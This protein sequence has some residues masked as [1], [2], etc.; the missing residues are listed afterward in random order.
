MPRLVVL[1]LFAVAIAA[2]GGSR[3]PIL[4]AEPALDYLIVQL[5]SGGARA[6]SVDGIAPSLED[7]GFRRIPVPPGYT[8]DEYAAELRSLPGFISVVPDV[9]AYAAALPDDPLFPVNQAAY[10]GLIKAP[11]AWD[12]ST[13]AAHEVIVAVLDSGMDTRHPELNS[14]LWENIRDASRDGIDDDNNGC[15]DDLNG[16]RF[17]DLTSSNRDGCGYSSSAATGN[18]LDDHGRAGSDQNSHGTLVAG[19]IG[20]AGNN[21][22]GLTG[23]SWDVRLMPVKVLDCGPTGSPSGSVY[24]VAQGIDYARRMGAR[25]I[26]LSLAANGATADTPVLRKAVADAEAQGVIIVAAAGNHTPSSSDVGPG[27][28]AAYTQ[29]SN[30][31]AVGASDLNGDWATFSNYGPALD[32]AAP[33]VSIASTTR[34]DLGFASPYGADTR[35]GTSFSTPLVAGVI[36][37]GI[38]RNPNLP[39]NDYLDLLFASAAPARPAV[40]GQN[41]AGAGIV[42]AAKFV[43]RIPLTLSGSALRDFKDVPFGTEIRAFVGAQECGR[44]TTTAVGPVSL[45]T[46]RVKS[47]GEQIDCGVPG[48]RV[49]VIVGGFET[50]NEITWP[51]RDL[52]IGFLDEDLTAVSPPPGP[53][54]VQVLNG[55]WSNIA[56]LETTGPPGAVLASFGSPW[57]TVLRW[58]PSAGG[59]LGGVYRRYLKDAPGYVNDL[60]SLGRYE[61]I[62]IDGARANVATPN[63][64]PVAGRSVALLAGWNN[65]VY[66]GS[67]RSVADALV[68]SAGKYARVMQFDNATGTW[69]SHVPG[70]PRY[71]NDFN[72]LFQLQVYWIYMNEPGV[73]V[74]R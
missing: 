40:H 65:I 53:V 8:A 29:F 19:I 14:R 18:I 74:M 72:G 34:T 16:C 4:A 73:I 68:D 47:A 10:L 69:T 32:I 22:A 56:Q 21:G 36:A 49:R 7:Q 71:L 42:D 17:V 20:A 67:A 57:T 2:A 24:N 58:D 38:A 62:W 43:A 52:P 27:Y 26:N 44:T 70:M 30:V 45:Y 5:D 39:M 50:T 54:V 66:T 46:L 64:N 23:V 31:V 15:V 25:I 60:D 41:W 12:L 35:G 59:L 11:G 6:Q 48:S 61:A 37:L 3:L 55:G 51:G 9:R 1:L 63:P 13:G 28:P 33:G